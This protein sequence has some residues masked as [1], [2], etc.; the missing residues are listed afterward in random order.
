MPPNGQQHQRQYEGHQ[1]PQYPNQ[2]PNANYPPQSQNQA[3]YN[4]PPNETNQQQYQGYQNPYPQQH[5]PSQ[6]QYNHQAQQFSNNPNTNIN[7]VPQPQT[8]TQ[9]N[10]SANEPNSQSYQGQ[11]QP[12]QDPYYQQ[13]EQ[14]PSP[15]PPIK[16]FHSYDHQ[17][18]RPL[19][20]PSKSNEE[21]SHEVESLTP[22]GAANASRTSSPSALSYEGEK[23]PGPD[24]PKTIEEYNED[25]F[26]ISEAEV[27]R[28]E[29]IFPIYESD[30]R[31]DQELNGPKHLCTFSKTDL[32]EWQIHLIWYITVGDHITDTLSKLEFT[33]AIHLIT[34]TTEKNL[35]IP[36]TLPTSLV[37]F[38]EREEKKKVQKD[39]E[40]Q[41][42]DNQNE[43]LKDMK[44]EILSL[45]KELDNMKNLKEQCAT[46]QAKCAKVQSELDETKVEL[47]NALKIVKD[48]NEKEIEIGALRQELENTKMELETIQLSHENNMSSPQYDYGPS[49][50]APSSQDASQENS[51]RPS[52]YDN[53]YEPSSLNSSKPSNFVPT[54]NVP[55]EKDFDGVSRLSD[56]FQSVRMPQ[57]QYSNNENIYNN[58]S[59]DLPTPNGYGPSVVPQTNDGCKEFRMPDE[60]DN[61]IDPQNEYPTYYEANPE[62]NNFNAPFMNRDQ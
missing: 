41:S 19:A 15:Q 50:A 44:N 23:V 17:Q 28:Y 55:P 3:Q 40:N 57:H 21:L 9:Y 12:N 61:G 22:N 8:Q 30:E 27:Q 7:D 16:Q 5:Q 14:P 51:A 24:K 42:A 58:M 4:M 1:S 48:Y 39:K 6:D 13:Q 10:S 54:S 38:K 18:Q 32:E 2:N 36:S 62:Q 37:K 59:N 52:N 29:K 49:P 31:K 53:S 46:E 11:K 56:E 43:Q 34:C 45:K 26:F 35:P 25:P 60:S 20:K 33:I 47:Q